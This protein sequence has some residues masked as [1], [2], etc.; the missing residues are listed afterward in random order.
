MPR[1]HLEH[2]QSTTAE[3]RRAAPTFLLALLRGRSRDVFQ[4]SFYQYFGRQLM[5]PDL[6]R[7]LQEDA[8][9]D[10]SSSEATEGGSQP[11]EPSD[12]G[13]AG[14]PQASSDAEPLG[15][16]AGA[17]DALS[18]ASKDSVRKWERGHEVP[19]QPPDAQAEASGSVAKWMAEQGLSCRDV[20]TSWKNVSNE[21]CLATMTWPSASV[22]TSRA[23]WSATSSSDSS[24]ACILNTSWKGECHGNKP[25]VW[26]ASSN[27]APRSCFGC[28]LYGFC[29]RASR[30]GNSTGSGF[31]I[32]RH[33][34]VTRIGNGWRLHV[35]YACSRRWQLHSNPCP[36]KPWH[37]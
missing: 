9:D 1:I 37:Q 28:A 8:D 24:A 31:C 35:R 29:L 25:G 15:A 32:L 13:D 11:C 26:C 16:E 36:R 33:C 14:G 3:A 4:R 17:D 34:S 27:K 23:N 7:A 12:E 18:N 10:P 19:L 2:G 5:C 20:A 22:E 6:Q 30:K 21:T